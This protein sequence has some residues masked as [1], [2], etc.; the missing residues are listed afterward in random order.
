MWPK[1][2]RPAWTRSLRVR[3]LLWLTGLCAVAAVALLLGARWYGRYAADRA[4]D[5]ILY[6]SALAIA[7]Q[8]YARDGDVIVDLPYAALAMLG[9]ARNDSVYYRVADPAGTTVTGYADLPAAPTT[10]VHA[11]PVFFDAMYRGE[12]TRFV[13]VGQLLAEPG[14]SGW[15]MIQ[16]GQT[17]NVRAALAREM[18]LSAAVPIIA[19]MLVILALVWFGISRGLAPLRRVETELKRRRSTELA[20]LDTAAPREIQTLVDAMNHFMSRLD[21][22]FDQ[23]QRFIADAAHQIRT[24]LASLKAQAEMARDATDADLLRHHL[25]RIEHNAALTT[26]LTNQLLSNA[27]ITHRANVD[28]HIATDLAQILREALHEAIPVADDHDERLQIELNVDPAP[29]QGDPVALREALRNLIENAFQHGGDYGPIMIKLDKI[30]TGYVVTV[31]DHGPGI[32]AAQ[33][34]HVLER[35]ARGANASGAGSGLGLAIVSQVAA[36]HGG[37]LQLS[38]NPGGGLRVVL[39]VSGQQP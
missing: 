32:V 13:V 20:P 35:F 39:F 17:R 19:F 14:V 38:D 8:V 30:T 4:F 10:R 11:E 24:P 18:V 27:V 9:F 22:T 33:R 29:L 25:D 36:Q 5:R 34:A 26:R 21:T 6:A 23:M 12:L 37:T 28:H 31:A 1:L 15:A 2:S 16:V 3:L 7:E